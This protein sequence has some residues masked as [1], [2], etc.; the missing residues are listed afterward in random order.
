MNETE[1]FKSGVRYALAYLSDVY[2]G[3]VETDIWAE[4]MTEEE[5][6]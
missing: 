2:E 1:D 6:K 5:S 3:V 4:F